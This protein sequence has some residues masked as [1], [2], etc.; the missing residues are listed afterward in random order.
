MYIHCSFGPDS[1]DR[2]KLIHVHLGDTIELITLFSPR[3]RLT[4]A[5]STTSLSASRSTRNSKS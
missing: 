2:Y 1:C 4:Q 5:S 3:L